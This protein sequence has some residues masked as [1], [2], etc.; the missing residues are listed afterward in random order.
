MSDA[1]VS[2]NSDVPTPSEMVQMAKDLEEVAAHLQVDGHYLG[3]ASR[4]RRGARML[5]KLAQADAKEAS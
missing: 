2:A 4:A 3:A 1:S 5:W